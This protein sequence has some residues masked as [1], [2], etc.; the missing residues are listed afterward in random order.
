VRTDEKVMCWRAQR[1]IWGIERTVV[2]DVSD[3]LREGQIRG[4]A[5]HLA[6]RLKKLEELAAALSKA[7]SKRRSREEVDHE[8]DRILQGQYIHRVLLRNFDLWD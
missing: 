1:T 5:Q 8:V 2:V 4:L 7:R 6:P 3:K